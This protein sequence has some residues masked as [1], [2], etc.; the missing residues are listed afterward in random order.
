M[1]TMIKSICLVAGMLVA[2]V[3]SAQS[4]EEILAKHEAAMGGLDKWASVKTAVVKNK[5]SVQGMDIESKTSLVIGKSFRTEIEVMGNKIITVIDGDKGWMNRPAM[6]GGTGEPEDMQSEQ[7]KM[8]SSQKYLGSI[9]TNAK[10]DGYKIELVAK[11]KLD[12]ADVYLLTVTK[13][14][15]ED[16]KVYVSTATN[17]VVKTQ[18]KVQVNGQ[19]VETEASYSNY[20]MVNG[21]AFPFTVETANPMGGMMTVETVSETLRSCS[22][23]R[24]RCSS[25]QITIGVA[26]DS[27][28]RVRSSVACNIDSPAPC[29][30]KSCFG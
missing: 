24:N 6:M 21:L 4:T 22:A 3:A 12:G 19:E 20:K 26:A 8:S 14:S 7:V 25:L 23:T 1:K 2:T 30:A 16:S 29:N 27:R 5:F 11:E 10:K 18:A 13:P 9:L 17:Y 28:P 15:G